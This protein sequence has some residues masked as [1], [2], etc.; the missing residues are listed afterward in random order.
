MIALA[1][2]VP[3]IFEEMKRVAPSQKKQLMPPGW[4]LVGKVVDPST[5]RL[6]P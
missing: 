4:P 6:Y 5:V 1:H 2:T 3:L